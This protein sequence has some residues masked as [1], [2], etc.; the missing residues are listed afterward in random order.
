MSEKV[1]NRK[2][3][4][5]ESINKKPKNSLKTLYLFADNVDM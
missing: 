4:K 5:N 2:I 3:D 1:E